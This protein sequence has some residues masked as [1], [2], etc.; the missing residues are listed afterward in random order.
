MRVRVVYTHELNESDR[1][2]LTR[3]LG[4]SATREMVRQI[5]TDLGTGG[6]EEQINQGYIWLGGW[7][8]TA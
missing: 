7:E 8:V 3:Y 1:A 4:V 2:A 5:L 6:L